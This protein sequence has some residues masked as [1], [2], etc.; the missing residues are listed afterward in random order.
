MTKFDKEKI[1]NKIQKC[2]KLAESSNE[3]EAA[4]AAE[5]AQGLLE[6]YNLTMVDLASFENPSD[7]ITSDVTESG[8]HETWTGTLMNK[9]ARTFDCRAYSSSTGRGRIYKVVGFPTDIEVFTYTYNYLLRVIVDIYKKALKKEKAEAMYWS[10]KSTFAFKS[11]FCTGCST[12]I[13]DRIKEDRDNRLQANVDS[14]ALVV[15]KGKTVSTWVN[16]N[17][18][19]KSRTTRY[20]PTGYSKGVNAANG[21][22]LR[23][24]I[25]SSNRV[26]GAIAQS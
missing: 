8:R 12:R 24:A 21:I 3:N 15:T 7:I 5:K 25:K 18:N 19:L 9:L 20:N 11:G 1:I 2:F 4:V 22:S 14:R 26:N 23:N 16:K 17:L 10:R 13:A 6:R